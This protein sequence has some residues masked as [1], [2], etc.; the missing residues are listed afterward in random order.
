M[1]PGMNTGTGMNTAPVAETQDTHDR[2][3]QHSSSSKVPR[4]SCPVLW[5]P[6]CKSLHCES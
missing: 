5:H 6:D 3:S 1:Q 4:A 2:R